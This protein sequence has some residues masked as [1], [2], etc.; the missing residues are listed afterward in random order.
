V[1]GDLFLYSIVTALGR[2]IFENVSQGK[3]Q[4][5]MISWL[6]GIFFLIQGKVLCVNNDFK[7]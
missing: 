5:K 3:N 4:K 1:S 2:V 6:L 7:Y